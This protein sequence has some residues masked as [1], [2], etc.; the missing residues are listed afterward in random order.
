[1]GNSNDKIDFMSK[2]VANITS[3]RGDELDVVTYKDGVTPVMMTDRRMQPTYSL[4][5]ERFLIE[6]LY[7]YGFLNIT[8]PDELE[9]FR[10]GLI[11]SSQSRVSK[12]NGNVEKNER[13]PKYGKHEL[14][15]FMIARILIHRHH[16][17][18]IQTGNSQREEEMPIAI[19]VDD[20]LA[21]KDDY[22]YG[23]Y[24][25]S[26]EMIN[27]AAKLYCPDMTE[28]KFKTLLR[29]LRSN[30]P[31][32]KALDDPNL[33]VFKNGIF[34]YD[35][36]ELIPF[37]PE[38]VTTT[39]FQTNYPTKKPDLPV[40]KQ[41][42]GS[43]WT[44]LDFFSSMTPSA[45]VAK[46]LAQILCAALR[47]YKRWDQMIWFYSTVGCNGKGTTCAL[48]RNILGERCCASLNIPDMNKDFKLANIANTCA[49]IADENPVGTYIEQTAALKS[50]TTND[51]ILLNPKYR[52]PYSYN[53]NGIIIQCVNE[54][55][56]V[57]DKSPSFLRRLIL[58]PFERSFFGHE[59]TAI[60]QVYIKDEKVR[61]W[62]VWM[63]MHMDDFDKL[64]TP[65]ECD[66][67]K[68]T[69]KEINN[70]VQE[71]FNEVEPMLSW[72]LIPHGLSYEMYKTWMM[73][74]N[75]NGTILGRNSFIEEWISCANDSGRWKGQRESRFSSTGRMEGPEM[76]ILTYNA[77]SWI[78]QDARKND[79]EEQCKL[80]AKNRKV[81]Y[82]GIARLNPRNM[83]S[84]A[85]SVADELIRTD[86][87]FVSPEEFCDLLTSLGI[88]E[89][90]KDEFLTL[91]PQ[92]DSTDNDSDDT[93]ID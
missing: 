62:F 91:A 82:R 85:Q 40:F 12:Y 1:M 58:V 23:T 54:V 39:K 55:P 15:A 20:K 45:G 21:D 11:R 56:R 46:L 65:P 48:L 10:N 70:P 27:K 42:D 24:D 43:I 6:Y 57:K 80:P 47:P 51:P 87:K 38:Y 37:S 31:T 59:N 66:A 71:F 92:K 16:V 78:N 53:F 61:E 2:K 18:K 4:E 19:Y 7:A 32:K 14:E 63:A 79:K 75:P 33:S 68:N 89:N 52:T 50:I 64:D 28:S 83:N 86:D 3:E 72:D 84:D 36:K 73:Q 13:W 77:E 88:N 76:C 49:I 26:E 69:F 29:D 5:M 90:Y 93:T 30:A 67:L 8:G 25:L 44:P 41:P 17:I 34:K 60:K 9:L 74:N 35:T 81:Q 22:R